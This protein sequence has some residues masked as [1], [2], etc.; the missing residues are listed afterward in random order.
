MPTTSYLWATSSPLVLMNN[1]NTANHQVDP[2]VAANLDGTA[3]LGA[4]GTWPGANPI[5]IRYMDA[6][7]A[8]VTNETGSYSN[9]ADASIAPRLNGGFILACTNYSGDPKGD[10]RAV[11]IDA[12][13]FAKAFF[14]VD[15]QQAW[16]DQDPD[17][18]LLSDGGFVVTWTRDI[19][20]GDRDI[21]A[22][23]YDANGSLR[24]GHFSPDSNFTLNTTH[25]S[26][27][28][29]A[30]GGFVVTWE[31]SQIGSTDT[32][33]VFNRY[34]AWGNALGN[35]VVFDSLGSTNKNVQVVA[36][37]DG[38]FVVAYE[39]SG[40]GNGI[41]IT[42]RVFN[43]NG[44]ARTGFLHVNDASN[45]GS[46]TGDQFLP[47]LT[48][49]SNGGFVVGWRD[50][51]AHEYVQA[52]DA[53]GNPLDTN[54]S[55]EAN[56]NQAEI[57]G[58]SGG[59]LAVVANSLLGDGSGSS[60]RSQTFEL[61]RMVT[62]DDTNEVIQSVSNGLHE[63]IYG[64][65]GDDTV[66]FSKQL[67]SYQV[68]D[69]GSKIVVSGADGL[70]TLSH[71][72]H[73]QF[74]D[75]TIT[76]EDGSPLFD[77]VYYMSHNLDVF[78]A[79]V[80]ALDHFNTSGWHEGRDPNAFF[81]VNGY[82]ATNPDAKALGMN[83]LD[84]YDQIGWHQ[85]RDPGASF[86]TTLYLMHNPDVA[87]VGMDPLQHYLQFGMAEGRQAYQAIGTVVNG[88]D[89]EYYLL[90]NPDVAALG[91]DP[92][93]HFNQFGWHEGRNPNA[94][95]DT[96]GYLAHY[97]DV[98]AANIN[99]LQHYEQVGWTE[100]RDPS[101]GF[102]TL[103]YLAANGDVAAAHINPLDHFINNGIYEGRVAVD[104]GMWH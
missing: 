84:H 2:A 57:A 7:G 63:F 1:V 3:F 51:S 54:V 55:L 101:P 34:D 69:L 68:T 100:G 19:G 36:L 77:T 52:Y 64:N 61:V 104:D 65:G 72:E 27:A 33:A 12:K 14:P 79:Q 89:A 98:A 26:V 75:G 70:H 5:D 47:S 43:A 99:P 49:L 30:G 44:T 9:S 6:S 74:A 35:P 13:G 56:V 86:D 53:N 87:A 83:P 38:G 73:L 11:M 32:A 42:A 103:G 16:A 21:L 4:W 8:P 58:L 28:G 40:W 24:G 59:H 88:F 62:G 93:Q 22:Q 85:G 39:D 29:L 37:P 90:H 10:I 66:V 31:Q 95:F 25:S 15:Q 81:S 82:L 48:T 94:W 71:V 41:D 17:V 45:G 67:A 91:I 102:D 46:T 96:K 80:N 76:P 97:A 78:H 92:L 60:I 23:I 50:D 18:A 20:G